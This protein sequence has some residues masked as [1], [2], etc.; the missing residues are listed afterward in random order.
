[1]LR[2]DVYKQQRVAGGIFEVY[3]IRVSFAITSLQSL[4]G[5]KQGC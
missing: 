4:T 5:L 2:N 1:M 3:F